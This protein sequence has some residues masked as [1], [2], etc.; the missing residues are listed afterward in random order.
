MM[1]FTIYMLQMSIRGFLNVECQ[2]RSASITVTKI[3]KLFLLILYRNNMTISRPQVL[4]NQPN[5]C[6]LIEFL[7]TTINGGTF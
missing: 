4:N 3:I 1:K 2:L 7:N 6:I 5:Q